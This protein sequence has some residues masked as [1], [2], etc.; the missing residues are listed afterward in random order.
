MEQRLEV[1]RRLIAKN[2]DWMPATERGQIRWPGNVRLLGRLL[3]MTFMRLRRNR[4]G[5]QQ[6]K[7]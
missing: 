4:N 6:Q 5:R 1:Y 2:A 7:N 3:V